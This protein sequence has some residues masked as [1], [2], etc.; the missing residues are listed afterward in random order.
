M[1][2]V[3]IFFVAMALVVTAIPGRTQETRGQSINDRNLYADVIDIA[4]WGRMGN[5]GRPA[6]VYASVF[7]RLSAVS[8]CALEQR[9]TPIPRAVNQ[10]IR[11]AAHATIMLDRADL[12]TSAI[13]L[14]EVTR[15]RIEVWLPKGSK[16][17]TLDDLAG[18]KVGVLRGPMYHEA[19]DRDTRILKYPVTSPLN[20]LEM[21][22]KGR[23][24]AAIGVHENFLAAISEMHVGVDAFA[25]P[26]VLEPRIVKLWVAPSMRSHS[27]TPRLAKALADMRRSGEMDRLV[28]EAI[29]ANTG[30][31]KPAR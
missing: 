9:L 6:G 3:S 20:Q 29:P 12:N 7:K 24:D 14:G 18:K 17:R 5:D 10:V 19:F 13:E 2:T 25:P 1:T 21:L 27:C 16:L 22:G 30:Y 31:A 11:D 28:A 26:I 23:L 8:G 4:P 15:L